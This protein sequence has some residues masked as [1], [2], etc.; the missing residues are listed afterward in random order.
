MRR[1]TGIFTRG[2]PIYWGLFL[3]LVFPCI[4]A[5]AQDQ[6][7][8]FSEEVELCLSCHSDPDAMMDLG[9]GQISVFVDPG[10]YAASVHGQKLNCTDCHTDITDYP[11]PER[12]YKT[13]RDINLALYE[14]CKKCH[15]DN[16]T[17]TLEGIHY[18]LL[19]KGDPRA[20]TCVDCHGSHQIMSPN[21]PRTK[22]SAT[23]NQCHAEVYKTYSESVHGKALLNAGNNDAPVCT[24]CHKAHDIQDPRTANFLLGTPELCGQCHSDEKIMKK[25]GL[26]THVV[27]TYLRDF[28]GVSASFHKG[29]GETIDKW[30]AVCTDCHGVHDIK[31]VDAQD[32]PVLKANLAKT[33]T[34]CHPDATPDFPDAWLSHY[35]PTPKKAALVYY[36]TLFYKFFIPFTIVGLLLHILL[37]IWRFAS[38]R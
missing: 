36:V 29:G 25:Y 16:Y 5:N 31:S 8:P 35:E 7:Q 4:P 15:F 32:S 22:I 33:C 24:D 21:R 1:I 26:S 12:S 30:K 9:S 23:C 14:S 10:G 13:K 20:P 6:Q 34:K 2:H 28:H 38:N 37:H 27:E 3:V 19:A 18:A 17:K 11:H